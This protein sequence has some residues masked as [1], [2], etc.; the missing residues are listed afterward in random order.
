MPARIRPSSILSD[1]LAGPMVQTIFVRRMRSNLHERVGDSTRARVEGKNWSGVVE[2]WSTGCPNST[3]HTPILQFHIPLP[4]LFNLGSRRSRSASPS[5]LMPSTV[6]KMHNP[7]KS[8]I[9]QAVLI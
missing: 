5:R 7:G 8:G 3:L 1:E 2:Y 6:M 4:V 9:H